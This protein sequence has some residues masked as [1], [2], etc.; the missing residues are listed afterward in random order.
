[1]EHVRIDI[2]QDLDGDAVVHACFD[3]SP[4][5][6]AAAAHA[7]AATTG[8]RFR[9]TDLS[10][11]DVLELRELT[12]LTDELGELTGGASTVVL[13]PAR[14]SALR[15]AVIA[16]VESREQAE[17][18]REEDRQPLALLREMLFP[19][20]QLGAEATRAALS[21]LEHRSHG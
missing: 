7:V 5:E 11:D 15:D 13:K 19:L 16:F 8:E 1:M 21:P 14:L 18:I 20:E 3:L 12:A 10:S 17:W 4:D 9:M 6:I 2:S